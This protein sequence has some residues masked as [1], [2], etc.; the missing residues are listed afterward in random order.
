MNT[1]KCIVSYDGTHYAGSQV[2]PKHRTIQG[3]LEKALKKIHKGE[4]IRIHSAGRTDKGVHAKGQVF[5]F[6]SSLR[7]QAHNWERALN[8]LL[9][10]DI[11]IEAVEAVADDFHARYD[12]VEKEYRYYVETSE[13]YDVFKRQYAYLYPYELHIAAMDEACTYFLGT[14]DF[15]TFASAKTSVKGSRIRTLYDVS[16][17]AEGTML[18]FT[19][20]G[21]GFLYN[22]VRIMVRALLDIGRGKYEATIVPEWLEQKDRRL[23]GPTAPPQGLYLWEVSYKNADETLKNEADF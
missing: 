17:E 3:E 18:I 1:F 21:N 14:H 6:Q 20:R 15:T 22:M 10:D 12:A 19:F 9:P 23:L 5:H 8:T 16:I 2:Q 7:M 11:F 4:G 13:H